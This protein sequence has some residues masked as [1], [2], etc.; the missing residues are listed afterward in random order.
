[1]PIK[2]KEWKPKTDVYN[3]APF[4]EGGHREVIPDDERDWYRHV[5]QRDTEISKALP[6]K[7]LQAANGITKMILTNGPPRNDRTRFLWIMTKLCGKS[8]TTV[9]TFYQYTKN[10]I[11]FIWHCQ[12]NNVIMI[13]ARSMNQDE[14]NNALRT[15]KKE[16][17]RL[18]KDHMDYYMKNIGK[19]YHVYQK[20]SQKPSPRTFGDFL[21]K[22]SKKR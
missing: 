13:I 20:P 12:K 10:P 8:Q 2:K 22:K 15:T 21:K 6:V 1:M 5:E 16:L 17:D 4:N 7:L 19:D 18:I 11:I 9:S 3:D 14:L